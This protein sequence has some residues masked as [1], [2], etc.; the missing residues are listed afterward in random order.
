V[1]S[2]QRKLFKNRTTFVIAH[3]LS[4]IHDANKIVVLDHGE[5]IEMGSHEELMEHDGIYADLYET[6]YSFQGIDSLDVEAI[7]ADDEEVEL[8]PMALLQKG[9]V[10]PEKIK[11]LMAEGKITPKMMAQLKER[12]K[13]QFPPDERKK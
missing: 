7:L 11:Q 10:D 13:S 5:L 1:Q 6:Y 4:T 9:R 3:R 2:A 12:A 8:S